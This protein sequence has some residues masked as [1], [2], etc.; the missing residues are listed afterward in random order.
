MDFTLTFEIES[1]TIVSLLLLKG[2]RSSS[3]LLSEFF[4]V[5]IHQQR[6]RASGPGQGQTGVQ[7]NNGD[8]L[9]LQMLLK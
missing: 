8:S 3:L 9:E 2:I 7:R 1:S 5:E 4:S 6:V